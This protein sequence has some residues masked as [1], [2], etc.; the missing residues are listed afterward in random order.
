MRFSPDGPKIRTLNPGPSC[1]HRNILAMDPR[2]AGC[3]QASATRSVRLTSPRVV[4][5]DMESASTVTVHR[6][7]LDA[8]VRG[9]RPSE[10]TAAAHFAMKK[11]FGIFTCRVT[12]L[13]TLLLIFLKEVPL[14]GR[15]SHPGRHGS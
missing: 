14:A 6:V 7:D 5:L 3:P 13:T 12:L 2:A 9:L 11:L 1:R 8:V 4:V 15:M 10:A